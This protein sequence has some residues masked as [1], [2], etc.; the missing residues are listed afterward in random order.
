MD[1]ERRLQILNKSEIPIQVS[2]RIYNKTEQNRPFGVVFD[3]LTPDL[4]NL[5]TFRI[6]QFYGLESPRYF[7]VRLKCE[8]FSF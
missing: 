4:P 1:S 6:D 3:T 5:W 8:L 2:W 7:K